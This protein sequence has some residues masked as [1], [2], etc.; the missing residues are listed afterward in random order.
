MSAHGPRRGTA[1]RTAPAAAV[2]AG[3]LLAAAGTGAAVPSG[4]TGPSGIRT[5][6]SGWTNPWGVD[7]LPDGTA[8]VTESGTLK[9]FEVTRSGARTEVPAEPRIAAPGSGQALLGI[10]VSPDWSRDHRIH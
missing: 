10:A 4:R 6:S 2:L 7:W 5:V 8:L 1:A 9:V 3:L